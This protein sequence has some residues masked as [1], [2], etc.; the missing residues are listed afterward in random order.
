MLSPDPELNPSSFSLLKKCQW[1]QERNKPF[2]HHTGS[3]KVL[4]LFRSPKDEKRLVGLALYHEV[5][6]MWI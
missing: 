2:F 3:L 4:P 6:K 1:T 5:E